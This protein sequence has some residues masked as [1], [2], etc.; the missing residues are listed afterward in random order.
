MRV[1]QVMLT[2]VKSLFRG[3]S[4]AIQ[5]KQQQVNHKLMYSV[6][7]MTVFVCSYLCIS[8]FVIVA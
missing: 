6:L 1:Q 3:V 4:D 7:W 2:V 8:T 5:M